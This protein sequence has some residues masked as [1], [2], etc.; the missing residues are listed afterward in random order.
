MRTNYLFALSAI[1]LGVSSAATAE[2]KEFRQHDAHQHGV[3]EWHIAQ[4]GDELLAEITAPGSDVVGFE[5]APENAEQKAAIEKA[6]AALAKPGALFAIN[7][8]A[9]CEL[10]AQQVT[11][12]LGEEEHG[13]HH[14]HD[15]E[16]H[17]D[18]DEHAH[19]DHDHDKHDDHDDHHG[20][21]HDKHDDHSHDKHE[22]HKG[23]DDHDHDHDHEHGKAQHGEFSA[24]YTFHC[25]SP[26]ELK[27]ITT[28]WFT[29][30]GNTEKISV[31]AV[32]DKGVAATE[33]MPSSTTFRF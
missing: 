20:H 6:V 4:D 19:D 30:F 1:A 11:H 27:S 9:G 21:D 15:H 26:A 23:H 33:L 13:D 28:D 3:V 17:H 32:T 10:E 2:N 12:T 16:G 14:D 25:K 22:E 18:H 5:H 7:S 31:Q 24:Q 8:K 29:A